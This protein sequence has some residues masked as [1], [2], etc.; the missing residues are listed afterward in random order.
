MATALTDDWTGEDV[1]IG[2]IERQLARL[3][4]E[5][6]AG[7]S[8]PNLRTSVMTH[9]AWAPP[10]WQHAAEETLAGM[11]ERHPSRTLL[12]VPRPE[13]E[14]GLDAL[15]SVRCFP[16]GDRAIC[17]EVIELSLR[18]ARAA[19]PASIVL[20]LLISDL[21]VFC[22]WR[23]R[24]EWE[25]PAFQQL[26][27]VIDRLVVDSTEW[28]DVPADYADLA[29]VVRPGRGVGHRVGSHGALARPARVAVAG[30]RGREVDHG[31][32]HAR[33]GASAAQAGWSRAWATT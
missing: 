2:E 23:G 16:F 31:A 32:R 21:P 8:Q 15:V 6:S 3:R 4:D 25:S 26:V 33:A 22:R 7:M 11:A 14:D 5:S 17:G 10:E 18:G 9:I 28:P 24:P 19:A 13:L 29:A 1:T 12:L 27:E 20:P 30:H